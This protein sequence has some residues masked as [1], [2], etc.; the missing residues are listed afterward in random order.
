MKIPVVEARPKVRIHADGA[1]L[2]VLVE[3][4]EVKRVVF[5]YQQR[6]PRLHEAH[7][8]GRERVGALLSRRRERA[9]GHCH[10]Q[11]YFSH[12]AA[13]LSIFSQSVLM[14]K[15]QLSIFVVRFCFLSL[16]LTGVPTIFLTFATN[17]L[18][19]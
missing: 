19:L 17:I 11:Q 3:Q 15:H 14:Q 13:K 1:H 12:S 18:I 9:D 16:R 10:H 5:G 8:R 2:T 7:P 6:H 4:R